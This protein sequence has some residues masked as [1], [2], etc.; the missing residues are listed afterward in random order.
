M[1]PEYVRKGLFSRR[2]DNNF[3]Y[4]SREGRRQREGRKK[5]Q[6]DTQDGGRLCALKAP[7]PYTLTKG[8]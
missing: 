2:K 6:I 5:T 1:A 4:F 8:Q 7:T 3:V